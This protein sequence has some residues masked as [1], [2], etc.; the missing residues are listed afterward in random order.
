VSFFSPLSL[1]SIGRLLCFKDE[2][3]TKAAQPSLP[4]ASSGQD[5]ARDSDIAGRDEDYPCDYVPVS[6][7]L[8]LFVHTMIIPVARISAARDHGRAR[9]IENML[10]PIVPTMAAYNPLMRFLLA[11]VARQRLPTR[12]RTGRI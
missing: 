1:V 10:P 7:Q 2:S 11:I 3:S 8:V 12:S 9:D 5:R 6:L 4:A